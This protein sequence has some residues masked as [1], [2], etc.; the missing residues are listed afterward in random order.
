MDLPAGRPGR[1]GGNSGLSRGC[2]TPSRFHPGITACLALVLA[3]G[4]AQGPTAV[5]RH[6]PIGAGR[7]SPQVA[8]S[9]NTL[10]DWEN[11]TRRRI[12]WEADGVES[13]VALDSKDAY[14]FIL[15]GKADG[16][17]RGDAGT[18]VMSGVLGALI[19][20]NPRKA[21]VIGLGTGSTAGWLGAVP[22]MER[23]DVAELESAILEVARV[24]A[25]ANQN[26]LGN[27]KVH[28]WIGDAREIS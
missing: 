7:V 1:R 18:Q 27:P 28:T 26:V 5:W 10:K 20:P 6:S 23:V 3:L 13:S 8:S 25:P 16:N 12:S 11:Q 4:W 17:I 21:M 22:T 9:Y 24:C 15:N 14:A 2:A 19:H